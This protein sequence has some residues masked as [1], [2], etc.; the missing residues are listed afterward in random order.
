M[1]KICM[2]K[3]QKRFFSWRAKTKILIFSIT[4][5]PQ[6]ISIPYFYTKVVCNDFSIIG[7]EIKYY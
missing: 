7:I 2:E 6:K 4:K 3:I 5:C 1:R